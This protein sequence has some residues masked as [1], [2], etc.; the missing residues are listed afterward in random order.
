MITYVIL[1]RGRAARVRGASQVGGAAFC[2]YVWMIDLAGA[3]VAIAWDIAAGHSGTAMPLNRSPCVGN[4]AVAV[5]S[6]ALD[7]RRRRWTRDGWIVLAGASVFATVAVVE[8]I[9]RSLF[10]RVDP[11]PFAMLFLVVC[12]GYVVANRLFQ[13][14]RRVAPWSRAGDGPADPAVDPA[15]ASAGDPRFID[16][17]ALRLDGGSGRRSASTSSSRLPVS[18]ACSSPTSPGMVC[19]RR[20]WR[21]WSRSR[22]RCQGGTSPIPALVLTRM[23]RALC[24]RFELAYVTATFALIDPAA[25]TLTYAAAGHPLPCWCARCGRVESLDERGMVLGFLP[26]ASLTSAIVRSRGGRSA[27]VLH[28]RHHRGVSSRW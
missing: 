1:A 8:N 23:N 26:D 5:V 3:M 9:R 6:V 12:L 16:R 14:E 11:E 19:L 13:A 7:T 28:R 17:R 20:L 18:S 10:G 27:R 24:G 15:E 22:W 21:R 25:G 2:R 4:I